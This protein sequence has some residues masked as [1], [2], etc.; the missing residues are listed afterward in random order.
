ME[1][2][3]DFTLGDYW[4]IECEHPEYITRGKVRMSLRGGISCVLANT[5]R[6]EK[7]I[8]LL[9]KWMIVHPVSLE[10]VENHNGNLRAPTS[11]GSDRDKIMSTYKVSGYQPVDKDYW[12]SVESKIAIYKLKNILKSRLPDLARIMMYRSATLRRIVFHK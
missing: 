3:S 6:A 11:R 12:K 2:V 1:R 10:S 7:M 5:D 4:E 8:P 9:E